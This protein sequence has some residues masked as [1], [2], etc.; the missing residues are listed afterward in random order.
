MYRDGNRD[1]KPYFVRRWNELGV[2]QKTKEVGERL[3]IRTHAEFKRIVETDRPRAD[4]AERAFHEVQCPAI[5]QIVGELHWTHG[6]KDVGLST[7]R[8]GIN[9]NGFATDIVTQKPIDASGNVVGGNFILVDAVGAVGTPEP[10]PNAWHVLGENDNPARPWAE[11]PRPSAEEPGNGHTDPDPNP[12]PELREQ[13]ALL[14]AQQAQISGRVDGVVNDIDAID[15]RL[16]RVEEALG[17][18]ELTEDRVR[19]LFS[20]MF[21]EKMRSLRVAGTV[22]PNGTGFLRHGHGM[23]I[24]TTVAG[25]EVSR[26]QL[27]DGDAPA[28][29]RTVASTDGEFWDPASVLD[30]RQKLIED[31]LARLNV[32]QGRGTDD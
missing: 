4:A 32:V 7:K 11:P 23:E 8:A 19:D 1:I 31:E 20:Q 18:E 6:M 5:F 10:D 12:D 30:S 21:S 3:G 24:V 2:P 13:V 22:K 28:D 26:T 29:I 16:S 14:G 9:W 15:H 25:E 17:G 27:R